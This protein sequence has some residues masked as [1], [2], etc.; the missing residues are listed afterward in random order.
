MNTDD[1]KTYTAK[2]KWH[3]NH[4]FSGEDVSGS[5]IKHED[6][7]CYLYDDEEY[8]EPGIGDLTRYD[9]VEIDESTLEEK[10]NG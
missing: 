10:Y 9:W 2:V 5:K 7:K 8:Y 6:D 4:Y 3:G 1:K